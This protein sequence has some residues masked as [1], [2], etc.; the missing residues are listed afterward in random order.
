M[1]A[2]FTEIKR[3]IREDRL[4][5]YILPP[6]LIIVLAMLIEVCVFNLPSLETLGL[7]EGFKV[8]STTLD[9]Q[10]E[11]M[12]PQGDAT[13]GQSAESSASSEESGR[14]TA[15]R[16]SQELEIGGDDD[17]VENEPFWL[18]FK[19]I[20]AHVTSI[21]FPHVDKVVQET[22]KNEDDALNLEVYLNDEGSPHF[23]TSFTNYRLD[24]DDPLTEYTIVNATGEVYGIALRLDCTEQQARTLSELTLNAAIP[25][26]I[27]GC[28]IA[29]MLIAFSMV[30]YL[31]PRSRAFAIGYVPNFKKSC[32]VWG[33][34]TGCILIAFVLFTTVFAEKSYVFDRVADRS[35]FELAQA[36][37]QGRFSLLEEP[38]Q[39]LKTMMF[40]YSPADRSYD[41]IPFLWDHAYYEGAYYVYFGILPALIF[42]LP[43]YLITGGEF[44]N[45]VA[46]LI[47]D[48]IAAAALVY[49]LN[50][51]IRRWFP[52]MS[53]GG[54]VCALLIMVFGSWALFLLKGA[55]IYTLPIAVG[56]MCVFW[57]LAFW[58][59]S[60]MGSKIDIRFASAGSFFAALTLASRP[61]L[62]L[63]CVFGLVL[64]IGALLR[65][66]GKGPQNI[67]IF[68]PIIIVA[69]LVG[70]Y[71]FARFGSFIDF[72]ANYNL[73]T[74]DMTQRVW[75][76][77]KIPQAIYYYLFMPP[78]FSHLSPYI[79][80]QGSPSWFIGM[81]VWEETYGG[82]LA[83]APVLLLGVLLLGNKEVAKTVK[84]LSLFG[85]ICAL[86]LVVFDSE[87]AGQLMRYIC[88]FGTFLSLP[89]LF[90]QL[91]YASCVF[92]AHEV[93]EVWGV[94]GPSTIGLPSRSDGYRSVQ[95]IMT[96]TL[97]YTVAFQLVYTNPFLVY[98]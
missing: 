38:S 96:L 3:K 79:V 57:A 31:R 33:C 47:V 5:K 22:P 72:G 10:T 80:L 41:K 40:P 48:I 28:R 61:Q 32:I 81:T 4:L 16:G 24:P 12:D 42:H 71:N 43:Y 58:I 95:L 14:A 53:W 87:S 46:L 51:I 66:K 44:P 59:R 52:E 50:T 90:V 13:N 77:D 60:T 69:L 74:N 84:V 89:A 76:I 30:W 2:F 73:T 78:E 36:L 39:G 34:L 15:N 1:G 54:F 45:Y 94:E 92:K 64:F 27:D 20:N 65:G 55:N 85:I 6:F 75:T 82:L 23:F 98:H 63:V 97:V 91:H 19:G 7:G 17:A 37:A 11:E 9:T 8:V 56:L 21:R 68:T 70:S 67:I 83:V 93:E 49:L 62:F 86:V 18:E 25:F 29:V 26:D 88:D 35:Y